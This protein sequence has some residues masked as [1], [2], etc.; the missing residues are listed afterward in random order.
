MHYFQYLHYYINYNLNRIFSVRHETRHE[1][2]VLRE[3]H[4]DPVR[5]G[6]D[7]GVGRGQAAPLR[8]VQWLW[9]R[10]DAC[11]Y[12]FLS[13]FIFFI[14]CGFFCKIFSRVTIKIELVWQTMTN[15]STCSLCYHW[16]FFRNKRSNLQ[17]IYIYTLACLINV[18]ILSY[19][20]A[21]FKW[22]KKLIHDFDRRDHE[23]AH[24]SL[25]SGGC[26]AQ[27]SRWVSTNVL[28]RDFT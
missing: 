2:K 20:L 1:R 12:S 17:N 4:R 7:R 5:Q 23:A 8:V 19:F 24:S 9:E 15:L 21:K 14:F 18:K 11:I 13:H 3:Q 25:R 27:L 10:Q 26:R 16:V 6:P 28:K 22:K